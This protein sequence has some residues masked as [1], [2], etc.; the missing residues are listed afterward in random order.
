MN[1]SF[2]RGHLLFLQQRYDLAERE[3][4]KALSIDP[5][6]VFAQALLAHCLCEL[7]K[8]REAIDTVRQAIAIAPDEDYSYYTLA[9]ILFR[10]NRLDEARVA[11]KKAIRLDPNSAHNFGQAALIEFN[12]RKWEES[13]KMAEQGLRID[14]QDLNSHIGKVRALDR[15]GRKAEAKE[16][17]A[18]LLSLAPNDP[19]VHCNA[20]WSYL[21]LGDHV[22]SSEHFREAL[23]ISPNMELAQHGFVEALKCHFAIYRYLRW[24]EDWFHIQSNGNLSYAAALFW[25][26][27]WPV[28]IIGVF[29]VPTRRVLSSLLQFYDPIRKTLSPEQLL[30]SRLTIAATGAS[31]ICFVTAIVTRS[32]QLFLVAL[33]LLFVSILTRSVFQNRPGWQRKLAALFTVTYVLVIVL[34]QARI[35]WLQNNGRV[36]QLFDEKLLAYAIVCGLFMAVFFVNLYIAQFLPK[37]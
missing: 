11:I 29:V 25:V 35:Y 36:V 12:L 33:S 14:P 31:I 28:L 7:E 17:A 24:I 22:R 13:L 2:Q 6:H 23:R 4:R 30:E 32:G 26:L 3:F 21:G 10:C 8:Y 20:G 15:L 1:V 19:S 18:V 37:S 16:A 27:L 5:S 9:H 34:I